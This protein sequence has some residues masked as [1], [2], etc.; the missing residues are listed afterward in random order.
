MVADVKPS[1]FVLT[2]AEPDEDARARKIDAWDGQDPVL[3]QV[4]DTA[5]AL[6]ERGRTS[7]Y[8]HVHLSRASGTDFVQWYGRM[9]DGRFYPIGRIMRLCR[10]HKTTRSRTATRTVPR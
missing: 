2:L 7:I 5:L 9:S 4:K 8:D 1:N 3:D 10:T 6:S